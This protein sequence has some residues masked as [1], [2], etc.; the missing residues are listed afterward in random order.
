MFDKPT[1]PLS[2][3]ILLACAASPAW[4]GQHLGLLPVQSDIRA[5]SPLP[6]TP[7]TPFTINTLVGADRFYNE[8]YAGFGV[9]IGNVEAG[10]VWGGTDPGAAAGSTEAGHSFLR[11]QVARYVGSPNFTAGE[12]IEYDLHATMVGHAIAGAG[13]LTGSSMGIA[14]FSQLWSGAIATSFGSPGDTRPSTSF[15]ITEQ[16]FHTVYGDFFY[17]VS[18]NGRGADVVNSSWGGGNDTDGSGL[19]ARASDGLAKANPLTTFVT[20][21]GNDGPGKNTVT[22]MSAAY[23]NITVGALSGPWSSSPF[24]SAADFSSRGASDFFNPVTGKTLTGVRATVDLVAPG[25]DLRLAAYLGATGGN[26]STL[27]GTDPFAGTPQPADEYSFIFASGTSFAAPIVAGGVGLLK[28]VAYSLYGNNDHARDSLVMKSVLQSSADHAV[29]GW[30]NGQELVNGVIRTEQALD[31]T[32]GAGRLDLDRAFET[33]ASP[34]STADVAGLTFDGIISRRGWDYGSLTDADSANQYVFE[35]EL[36]GPLSVTLNWFVDRTY[37]YL[38]RTEEITSD[39][40]AFANLALEIWT[41]DDQGN[42]VSLYATSDSEY[43]N[44]EHLYVNMAKGRY[45]LRVV[46]D[47]V[48]YGDLPSVN[49]GLAWA[50]PEAST[51]PAVLG[52]G[53]LGLLVWRRRRLA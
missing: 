32:Y 7:P 36:K 6:G 48:V 17:G 31:F 13:S 45:A 33:F 24:R 29:L 22:D 47:G 44:T 19:L 8:G 35:K 14:P 18:A 49:F 16:S 27:G 43:N 38:D 10:H 20:S 46:W 11:G 23:N 39:D 26:S 25:E 9:V 37:S 34:D 50:V 28:E 12:P 53:V 40:L 3:L 51:H 21:A 1:R 2:Q 41:T 5:T 15:S 30:N 42:L 52:L 4:A